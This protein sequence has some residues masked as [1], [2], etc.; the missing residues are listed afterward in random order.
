MSCSVVLVK[1][2]VLEE[3][4]EGKVEGPAGREEPQ[5]TV[6]PEQVGTVTQ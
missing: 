2:I 5:R 3:Q 1:P 4:R 6:S